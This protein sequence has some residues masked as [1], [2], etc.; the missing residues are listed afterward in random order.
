MVQSHLFL[1]L[2]LAVQ[3][4]PPDPSRQRGPLR[5]SCLGSVV[6][7]VPLGCFPC[8]AAVSHQQC[9]YDVVLPGS[10]VLHIK[11]QLQL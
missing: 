10:T 4:L 11:D 2:P 3:L 6:W 5:G 7:E 8:K 9:V 1:G